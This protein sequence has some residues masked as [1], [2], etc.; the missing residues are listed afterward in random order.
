ML[1]YSVAN[2]QPQYVIYTLVT[3]VEADLLRTSRLRFAVGLCGHKSHMALCLH[4]YL[5]RG[6]C[7]HRG[8]H[9]HDKIQQLIQRPEVFRLP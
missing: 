8:Q 3:S 5:F 9:L 4:A 7:I 1:T 2:L 6:L